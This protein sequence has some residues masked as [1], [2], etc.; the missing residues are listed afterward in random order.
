MGVWNHDEPERPRVAQAKSRPLGR[1][2]GE[3]REVGGD[4]PLGGPGHG[5]DPTDLDRGGVA[6][7]KEE[8]G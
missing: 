3:P 2:V 4:R 8:E 1:P 5:R 6:L 7:E